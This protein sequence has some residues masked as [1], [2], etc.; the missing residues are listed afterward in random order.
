MSSPATFPSPIWRYRLITRCMRP[1]LEILLSSIFGGNLRTLDLFGSAVSYY[2]V[3]S[4]WSLFGTWDEHLPDPRK[5][6]VPFRLFRPFRVASACASS[7]L[8][9][10][11]RCFFLLLPAI[12]FGTG[13]TSES[14]PFPRET[15]YHQSEQLALHHYTHRYLPQ[16]TF[17]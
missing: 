17:V 8:G 7:S 5:P 14:A 11:A 10:L 3:W 9:G 16:R 15:I 6:R 2:L 4:D 1:R 12:H 13:L